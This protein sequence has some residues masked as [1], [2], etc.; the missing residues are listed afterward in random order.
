MKTWDKGY[1]LD[2][3]VEKFT[4]GS[5]RETDLVLAP[6]DILGSL[7]HAMM[8]GSIGILSDE[9][10]VQL[11]VELKN[12]YRTIESGDF[13]IEPDVEDIHSQVEKQLTE[14]L[15]DLGKKIHTGR[16]RND[17]VLTDLH[18][19][20]RDKLSHVVK[21][22]GE[23]AEVLIGMSDKNKK[24]LLPGYTHY[25]VAMPASFGLWFASFAESLAD[26]LLVCHTAY[27]ISDQN[28]LGS[29]AGFGS[30]FPLKR[31]LTTGL[32]GFGDMRYNVMHAMKSRGK[33][34]QLTAQALASVGD[35][36]AK[37]ASDVCLYAGQDYGFIELPDEYTTG[38]SIMPHKKNPDLFEMIR[39]FCNRLRALPN[40]MAMISSNLH[41]GYHRE[42]QLMKEPLFEAFD[43]LI[44]C[45]N[46]L[47]KVIPGLGIK[48]V[49]LK[50]EK[51][52]YLFSV[53]EVNRYVQNGLPFREA[54]Q[55][56]AGE[57]E[58]GEYTPGHDIQH[59]HEGSIGNL[60]NDEVLQ[61]VNE[62]IRNF[63]FETANKALSELLEE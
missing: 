27:M 25:Q 24:M 49:D 16:S 22:T 33:L 17:Q 47:K 46:I 38:S 5:D 45:L 15:G 26:D 32:L 12:I 7:A 57:I 30:S 6:Y 53:E 10:T 40:E 54:Y 2:K 60:C 59:S 62:R 37:L 48:S 8:L 31:K 41:T 35:T 28:P 61:K 9:E 1:K 36:L 18:L 63:N 21:A 50:Q 55:K 13:K 19:F 11:T 23:L 34:E 43:V 39:G 4:V 42:F 51:Y 14:K 29:G 3:Q 52:N 56:V 44:D 58:N 20:I